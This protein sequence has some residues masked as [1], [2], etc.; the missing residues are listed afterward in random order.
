[1]PKPNPCFIESTIEG[2]C[3]GEGEC[4]G[5]GIIVGTGEGE[6]ARRGSGIFCFLSDDFE[7]EDLGIYGIYYKVY[8]Y[9]SF[10]TIYFFLKKQKINNM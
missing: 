1:M 10:Y 2:G 3:E 6:G 8:L 4:E 5:A 9:L 7:F